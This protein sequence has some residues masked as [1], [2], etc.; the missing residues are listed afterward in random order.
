MLEIFA[1]NL[2]IVPQFGMVLKWFEKVH[3]PKKLHVAQENY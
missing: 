3:K 2:E 1:P